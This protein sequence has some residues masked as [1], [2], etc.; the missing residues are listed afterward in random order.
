MVLYIHGLLSVG[1]KAHSD[2]SVTSYGKTQMN[3]LVNPIY[4]HLLSS[5][6][7]II[8][9]FIFRSMIYF[10]LIF[11]MGVRSASKFVCLG[12]VFACGYSVV[13]TALLK[14]LAF[15]LC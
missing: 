2:F 7:F 12:L 3:I 8:W 6:S 9:G 15:T 11:V 10:E 14:R 1:Q 4:F 13:P 5:R